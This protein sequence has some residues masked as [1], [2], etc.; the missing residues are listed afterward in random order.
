MSQ[1]VTTT[2]AVTLSAVLH[3]TQSVPVEVSCT[4][5]PGLQ[6]ETVTGLPEGAAKEILAR[7]T[8]ALEASGFSWPRVRT[9]TDVRAVGETV[10][11]NGAN[12]TIDLATAVAALSAFGGLGDPRPPRLEA[13]G[14]YTPPAFPMNTLLLGGLDFSGRLTPIRGTM[15]HVSEA[16]L[17]LGI[18][19][20]VVPV[21]N[22]AEA[23]AVALL[24]PTPI[25]IRPA[26]TLAEVVAFLR[27]EKEIPAV[28]PPSSLDVF[29]PGEPGPDLADIRGPHI[30]EARRA[31]EVAATGRHSV[32]FTGPPNTGKTMLAR[33]LVGLLPQMTPA[34]TLTT[35]C[36][37]SAMGL[38]RDGL[39]T[40]RPFRAP[41]HT[42][43]V[44]AL[45]GG[46]AG[47]PRPGEVSL[48]HNG[49]LYLDELPEF[50]EPARLM[51][52]GVAKERRVVVGR[53]FSQCVFPAD[54]ILVASSMACPCGCHG[55]HGQ[56]ETEKRL[57]LNECRC[58]ADRARAYRQRTRPLAFDLTVTTPRV[59]SW[60][61]GTSPGEST[62]DVARR[63]A[64]A[65]DFRSGRM[66]RGTISR[67]G[68]ALLDSVSGS[69][70]VD[71][72]AFQRLHAVARTIA[73]LDGRIEVSEDHAA[74]AI[75]LAGLTW[76]DGGHLMD[77]LEP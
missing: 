23:T 24:Y 76:R 74:E 62:S 50:T 15:I 46:G 21:Q 12:W 43:S 37:F 16:R 68:A 33:R 71:E 69:G 14:S 48:A 25:K 66:G 75:R 60:A 1:T 41:H 6:Q 22:V 55:C 38:A 42:I 44:A 39:T 59:A 10:I 72:V 4:V 67:E 11:G 13:D 8:T 61:S 47:T 19:N 45:C 70:V 34:E 58:G 36:L 18:R 52:A 28:G 77:L 63:V 54:F 53:L 40:H 17:R 30:Q 49:V 3:G 26:N 64:A 7:I 51:L 29:L 32:L 31:L 73:D 27:G 20:V 65:L 56:T 5:L 2:R 9:R 35:S 57:G